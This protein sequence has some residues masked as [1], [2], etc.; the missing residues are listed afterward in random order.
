MNRPRI[1]RSLPK[2]PIGIPQ[3]EKVPEFEPFHEPLIPKVYPDEAP[4]ENPQK[5]PIENPP[6]QIPKPNEFP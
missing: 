1:I 4:I 6:Y 5:E 2:E 3:P